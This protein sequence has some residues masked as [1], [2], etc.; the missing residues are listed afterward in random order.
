MVFLKV[1][2]KCFFPDRVEEKF[3]IATIRY[4]FDQN[5]IH[6]QHKITGNASAAES[7]YIKFSIKYHLK[8]LKIKHYHFPIQGNMLSHNWLQLRYSKNCS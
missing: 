7:I 2:E 1:C 4:Y 8:Y 5:Y 3:S 6:K